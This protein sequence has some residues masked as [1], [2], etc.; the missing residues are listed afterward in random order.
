MLPRLYMFHGSPPARA[1]LITARAIG[2]DLNKIEINVMKGEHLKPEY[3]RM[4]PQ[5]TIPTFVDT[6]GFVLWDSHSIMTYLVSKYA[7]NDKLYPEELK[8]RATI[9][10]RLF[11]E[12]SVVYPYLRKTSLSV[13]F[14]GKNSLDQ[15]DRKAANECYGFLE[16]F[17]DGRE[18]VAGENL[19]IADYSLLASISTLNLLI[20]VDEGMFPRVIAW[21]KKCE[22]LP[23][24]EDNK[25]GLQEMSLLVQT[26]LKVVTESML[27]VLFK[28][29]N[30]LDQEDRNAANKCYG[31]LE[32]FLD[33]REW[34][35]GENLSIADYSLLASI[36]TL[37]LL[38]SVDEEMFPRVIAWLKKCEELP[39]CEDNKKGL[40]EMSLLVQT[41][42]KV[43]T[44]S[45]VN[46]I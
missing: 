8:K 24:C 16:S 19:S 42:L 5:H 7:K 18:W 41:K 29:K 12:A 43:V 37:N 44:E 33:G 25:K 9:N 10:Q 40:Q 17:L 28:G 11:F 13:L 30:S 15:E 14:K 35:A 4:N 31:F 1:V 46:H 45:M 32:S 36:S 6:C 39:E 2:L 27:S 26:K 34:V 23:E 38:I 3:L 21:L 20:S 22:E